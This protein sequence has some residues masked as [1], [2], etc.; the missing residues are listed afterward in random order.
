M[1]RYLIR[2]EKK[3][4]FL[5]PDAWGNPFAAVDYY[6]GVRKS[7]PDVL[8]LDPAFFRASCRNREKR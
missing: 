2:R 1:Q 6:K 7:L 5:P 4:L 8:V 3:P